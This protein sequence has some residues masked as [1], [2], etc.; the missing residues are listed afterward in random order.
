MIFKKF[1]KRPS[2]NA[3]TS[4]LGGFALICNQRSAGPS[5]RQTS[6][7]LGHR[8]ADE[9]YEDGVDEWIA[10]EVPGHH[11]KKGS[12]QAGDKAGLRAVATVEAE[13]ERHEDAAGDDTHAHGDQGHDLLRDVDS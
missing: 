9:T 13:D 5:S 1:A 10:V 3:L 4:L 8:A 11:G 7:H 2:Y 6:H 12:Q